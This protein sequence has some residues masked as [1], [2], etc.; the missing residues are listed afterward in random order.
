MNKGQ[1]WEIN[2]RF[3]LHNS[4]VSVKTETSDHYLALRWKH[5]EIVIGSFSICG[6]KRSVAKNII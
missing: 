1:I 6:W 3:V 4:F 2:T 5:I